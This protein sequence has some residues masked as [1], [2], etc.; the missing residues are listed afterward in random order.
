MIKSKCVV[1]NRKATIS[2]TSFH[3]ERRKTFSVVKTWM[4]SWEKIVAST[5]D[6]MYVLNLTLSKLKMPGKV[7]QA[8][9]VLIEFLRDFQPF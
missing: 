6:G 7:K 4:R 8:K 5:W 3:L 1:T 2:M 9:F